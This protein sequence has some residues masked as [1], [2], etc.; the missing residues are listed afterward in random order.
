MSL[1]TDQQAAELAASGFEVEV[2]DFED[3]AEQEDIAFWRSTTCHST[4]C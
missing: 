3:D 4:T 1:D 2:V